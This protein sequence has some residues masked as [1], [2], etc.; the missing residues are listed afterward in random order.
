MIDFS[1]V[2]VGDRLWCLSCPNSHRIALLTVTKITPTQIVAAATNGRARRFKKTTGYEVGYSF[3]ADRIGPV[4]TAAEAE[5]WDR[6]QVEAEAARRKADAEHATTERTRKELAALFDGDTVDVSAECWGK[7]DESKGKWTLS[8][9][10]L[11][12]AQVRNLAEVFRGR[13]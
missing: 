11:T 8:L 6:A 5:A 7:R 10:G 3:M 1:I 9:H 2:Q 12:E 13:Q 4:A